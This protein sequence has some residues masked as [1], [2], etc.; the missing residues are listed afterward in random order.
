MINIM[1]NFLIVLRLIIT[2][3]VWDFPIPPKKPSRMLG[4]RFW[5]TAAYLYQRRKLETLNYDSEIKNFWKDHNHSQAVSYADWLISIFNKQWHVFVNENIFKILLSSYPKKILEAGC[6]SGHTAACFLS[7][8]DRFHD[9]ESFFYHG[10]DLSDVRVKCAQ[11]FIPRFVKSLE[12]S[13]DLK[14]E[15]QDLEKLPFDDKSYDLTL[16]PSVL[17]RVNESAIFNVIK[18]VCRVTRNDIYISD[19]Y[20]QYPRGYP[21]SPQALEEIFNQF[22]FRIVNEDYK[23]TSGERDYCELHLHLTRVKI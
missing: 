6:G 11:E 13:V 22:G 21:R 23:Y 12:R 9:K 16:I 7:F 2:E 18:E 20:D 8:A 4:L 10:V 5:K 15:V 19:F 17:E 1:K 14:F 3:H